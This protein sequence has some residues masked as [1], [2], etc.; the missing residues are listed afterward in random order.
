MRESKLLRT[1]VVIAG[2]ENGHGAANGLWF[3]FPNEID[4]LEVFHYP[5]KDRKVLSQG[6]TSMR[7]LRSEKWD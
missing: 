1:V 2:Q 6:S 7:S 5:S 3:S 4:Q